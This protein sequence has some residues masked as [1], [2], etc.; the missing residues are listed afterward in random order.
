MKKPVIIDTPMNSGAFFALAYAARRFDVRG[1]AV[2]PYADA[3]QVCAAA[4]VLDLRAPVFTGAV[5]PIIREPS[6]P[7]GGPEG[8]H[9]DS[10]LYFSLGSGRAPES[11]YAWDAIASE[12][13]KQAG[14]LELITLGSLTNAAI[15]L[16]KYPDL[17]SQLAR[18]TVMGGA[19]LDGD[20]PDA[21]QS[22]FNFYY[23]PEAA[24]IVLGSSIPL[25]IADLNTCAQVEW[26]TEELERLCAAVPGAGP[27]KQD[28]LR[29]HGAGGALGGL[30]AAA[31][32]DGLEEAQTVNLAVNVETDS[33]LARGKL[34]LEHDTA[35]MG[36]QSHAALLASLDEAALKKRI[37][38]VFHMM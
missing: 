30:T 24:H 26:R 31:L 15:A 28:F 16:L 37:F 36:L 18:I 1:V 32:A 20:C 35:A 3:L 12:A 29:R 19:R 4:G 33:P 21:P 5:R 34:I 11:G 23:D 6:F 9:D 14:R 38:N 8:G 13:K 27:L 17:V 22:E 10:G 7:R 2:S 25:V